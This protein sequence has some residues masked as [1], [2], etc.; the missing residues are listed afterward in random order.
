MLRASFLTRVFENGG[1]FSIDVFSKNFAPYPSFVGLKS[2]E[3]KQYGS[4]YTDEEQQF[5]IVTVDDK[6]NPIKRNGLEVKIYEI[7]WRWWWSSSYEDLSTYS[8]SDYHSHYKTFKQ[9]R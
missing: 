9:Y 8:G 1:D 7:N 2:P 5:D 4:F 6:G 3:P